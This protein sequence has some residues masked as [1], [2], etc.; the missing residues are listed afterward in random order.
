MKK[1]TLLCITAALTLC[2]LFAFADSAYDPLSLPSLKDFY[3]GYFDFGSSLNSNE[4]QKKSYLPFYAAQ[5]SII[6]PENELKPENVLDI[7]NSK[8]AAQDD[9]GNVV[10][11]FY[12]VKPL[13]AY[14]KEHGLKVHGHVLFWHSQTPD[15]FFRVSYSKT[16]EYVSRDIMLKRMENYVR[17]IMDY[18]QTNYPGLI[19]SW[20]VVNEAIDDSTGNLRE[21]NWTKIVGDD[22]VEQAFRFARAYAP[23]GTLLFYNDY[24]TPYQPKLNGI[25][26][27]LDELNANALIDGCGMQ[28]HYQMSTPTLSQVDTAMRRIIDKGLL[29]RISE[30]DILVDD[31]TEAQFQKQATRYADLM[32]VIL[33]YAD[34]VIAVQTWGTRDSMSWKSGNFPLLFNG[35]LTPKPA[36]DALTDPAI[37]PAST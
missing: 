16:E 26:S 8:K 21:S 36:F 20:D 24:S 15:E 25:L 12:P 34:S 1:L 27:L 18:M 6:T 33:K 14:A 31:N 19:V 29:I 13:L 5:Y 23:E 10:L 11:S 32:K 9:Q 4:L 3:A 28:F 22:F 37:L 35:N 17:Q 2:C 30:M 7:P